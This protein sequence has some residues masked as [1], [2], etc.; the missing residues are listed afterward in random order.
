MSKF[1]LRGGNAGI[2][3]NG[4]VHSDSDS[5]CLRKVLLRAHDIQ[6]KIDS[7]SELVFAIGHLNEEFFSE[8]FKEAEMY[9]ED[10][11]TEDTNFVGHSDFVTKEG[12][13]WELKSCTSKNTYNTVFK[14]GLAKFPN[15]VQLCHYMLALESSIGYLQYTSY[16]DVL[17]YKT[18]GQHNLHEVTALAHESAKE[19]KTFTVTFEDDEYIAID[20]VKTEYCIKDLLAYRTAAAVMYQTG[21]L[22][23]DRPVVTSQGGFATSTCGFCAFRPVCDRFEA[24]RFSTEE[25][26]KQS[27]ELVK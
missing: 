10:A 2:M 19:R 3:K 26:I 20:G 21:E 9:V 4:M 11:I 23:I 22:P 5:S 16:C 15:V 24:N 7:K 12:V 14:K 13:P 6:P 27:K 25:F 1:T 18:L 8:P 17:D